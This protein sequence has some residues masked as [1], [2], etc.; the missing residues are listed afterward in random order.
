[1]PFGIWEICYGLEFDCEIVGIL[2]WNCRELGVGKR[3]SKQI[4]VL[5]WIWT[6]FLPI[7]LDCIEFLDL[8]FKNPIKTEPFNSWQ[9]IIRVYIVV[10]ILCM[11][12]S[13]KI[14]DLQLLGAVFHMRV[15]NHIYIYIIITTFQFFNLDKDY[16]CVNMKFSSAFENVWVRF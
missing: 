11:W 5:E 9:F 4:K 1:M 12:Y 2:W 7:Q 10:C 6:N 16:N 8:N 14:L 3:S 15:S 13:M